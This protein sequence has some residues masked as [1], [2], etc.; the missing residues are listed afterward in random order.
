MTAS[1][2]LSGSADEVD[3]GE[4]EEGKVAS[5]GMGSEIKSDRWSILSS[6]MGAC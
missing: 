3:T 6:D 4:A 5:G 1:S 2:M